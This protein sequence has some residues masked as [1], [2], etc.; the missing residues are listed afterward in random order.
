MTP[1]KA[2]EFFANCQYSWDDAQN[3]C[4][5]RGGKL[6]EPAS[7]AEYNL[8]FA[9]IGYDTSSSQPSWLFNNFHWWIGMRS[10]GS[11]P[12]TFANYFTS[13]LPAAWCSLT[14]NSPGEDCVDIYI[15]KDNWGDHQCSLRL[16]FICEIPK[17]LEGCFYNGKYY[18]N[19]ATLDINAK[20]CTITTCRDGVW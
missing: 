2:V 6:W 20:C 17:P 11:G 4:R 15:N 1:G 16:P 14:E 8:V 9:G 13:G 12:G 7:L 3:V 19:G 5:R 10:P 18:P